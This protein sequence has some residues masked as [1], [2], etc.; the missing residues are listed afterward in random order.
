M[1]NRGKSSQRRSDKSVPDL[2][3]DPTWKDGSRLTQRSWLLRWDFWCGE[4]AEQSLLLV[5]SWQSLCLHKPVGCFN[6]IDNKSWWAKSFCDL[7]RYLWHVWY[8]MNLKCGGPA[9]SYLQ[10]W[11]ISNSSAYCWAAEL[12]V[13]SPLFFYITTWYKCYQKSPA[14]AVSHIEKNKD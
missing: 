11:N 1:M 5:R 13:N 7:N 10:L 9:H 6:Q 4:Q 8:I 14:P 3:G 12:Q 2:I